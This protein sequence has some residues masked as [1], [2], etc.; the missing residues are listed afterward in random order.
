MSLT[1]K[2]IWERYSH[3]QFKRRLYLKRL[4]ADG[5]YEDDWVEISQGLTKDGSVNSL[6]R[7]LPNDSWQ[8]GYVTVGNIS[9]E[10]L[11]PFQEF[12]SENDPNSIFYG[13]IRHKSKFKV[14]DALIDTFSG[15]KKVLEINFDGSD[16]ATTYTAETGQ[17]LTFAGTAQLDISQRESGSSSLL[18]DGNS[19]YVSVP[20]SDDWALLNDDFDILAS[21]RF[22]A[23]PGEGEWQS[24]FGQYQDSTD[25]YALT[26]T[27]PVGE[28]YHQI[29]FL[30]RVGGVEKILIT[31]NLSGLLEADVWYDIKLR[32]SGD[33]FFILVDDVIVGSGSSSEEIP[34]LSA[35]FIVGSNGGTYYFN[36]WIDS[37]KLFRENDA[38]PNNEATVTT[39]EGYIDA[40][41]AQ[42]EQGYEKVT[43][44]DYI[45]VLDDVNVAELTLAQT[46]LNA[47]VYEIL[48]R[49]I[50][51]KYFNVSSSTTYINAGYNISAI[52][53]SKYTGSVLEMLQDLAKGHSIFYIDPD[54]GYFYFKP[55]DPTTETRHEFLEANNRKLDISAWREGIDRQVTNWYWDEEDSTVA[56]V[57]D[58]APVNPI[59]EN[60]KIQGVTNTTQQQNVLN[61]ILTRTQYA[62]PYFKLVLPYFPVIKLLD[63]VSVQSFGSAP[64]DALRWGM[65]AWTDSA[66]L[67]PNA[68]PRWRKP[69]GIRISSDEEWMVRGIQ[70]SNNLKTTLELEK[71]L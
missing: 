62:K 71:I 63:R 46:T 70:H 14:V 32:R 27:R 67:N 54:D 12:A 18:L 11:S 42:T 25:R 40:T 53:V 51:T 55:A 21:I 20:D 19:D 66:T 17:T 34:N 9:L 3:V 45:S 10:I 26:I 64:K 2:Q 57:A 22:N 35:P 30:L 13:Y 8:F 29:Y 50:F 43:V 7:S 5:T 33:D 1:Y 65:F 68:A 44:M 38:L 47:L 48:N 37:F 24:V 4:N 61:Y 28:S 39:F 60:F 23:V 49:S 36:G 16:G 52:D 58:P 31:A 15:L 6:S 69:A 59:S 56:A 41:T